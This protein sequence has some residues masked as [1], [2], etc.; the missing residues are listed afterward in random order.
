MAVRDFAIFVREALFPRTPSEGGEALQPLAIV[1]KIDAYIRFEGIVRHNAKGTWSLT[2]PAGHPQARLLVQGRGIVVFQEGESEPLLSGPITRIKK[3]WNAENAGAGTIEVSGVDDNYL[4]GERLAWPNPAED[5]HLAAAFQHWQTDPTWPNVAEVLRQLFIA[6][7]HGHP[8]RRLDRVFIPPED[9]VLAFLNDE[10]SRITRLAFDRVDQLV[11]MLSAAYGFRIRF[12]WHPNPASTGAINGTSNP[13]G[14]GILLRIEPLRDLTNDVRLG[15]ELGT[16]RGYEYEVAAPE[17]TRI[18]IGCQNRTWQEVVRKPTYDDEGIE[19]G[20]TEETIE[21][22]EPQRW[23]GYYV[24]REYDPT[25]WGDPELTPEDQQHTIPWAQAGFSST[26]TEWGITAE[27]YKDRRD[28]GWQW[29]QDPRQPEGWTQDPPI[30]TKQHQELMEELEAFSLQEGPTASISLDLIETETTMYGRHFGLGDM[31]RVFVDG[32]SRDEVVRE[33][34]LSSTPEDGPRV[35]PMV[36]TYGST[37]TPYLYGQIRRLWDRVAGV[38]AR[39]DLRQG[40]EDIPVA[41]VV[42]KKVV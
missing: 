3:V 9:V 16:L 31:V 26:E 23:Y 39:D 2:I 41:K 25:W 15:P 17:A 6:N 13:Q 21:H 1:G 34:R 27:R 7:F 22:V 5:I 12:I 24:A 11:S 36:G 42:L 32:E 35:T 29:V 19:T 40:L 37:E 14:P 38:E 10:S 33:V 18:V 28:I 8:S 30:W 4:L 20:Y